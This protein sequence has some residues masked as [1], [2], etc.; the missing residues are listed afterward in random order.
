MAQLDFYALQSDIELLLRFVFDHTDC[1]VFE[2]Y[3]RP[4][5]QLREFSS[6]DSI[7][8]SDVRESN[9]GRYFLRFIS[10]TINADPIIR[11]YTLIKSGQARHVIESPGLYQLLEGTGKDS[12]TSALARSVFS[13]WN[14][15]GAKQR[16]A[17]PADVLEAL[18]WRKMRRISGQIQ[19]H[20]KNRLAVAKIDAC[21]VLPGASAVLNVSEK[22]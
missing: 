7:R 2:A 1:R 15:A 6:L 14:E 10:R 17:H 21:P 22:S 19:R 12:D 4:G 8:E 20:I 5:H 9:H 13:H 11:E 3:S 18:D 16:S